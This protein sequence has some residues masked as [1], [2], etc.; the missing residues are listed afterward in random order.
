MHVYLCLD[1]N[2]WNFLD[3]FSDY[4]EIKSN[5]PCL[6]YL[7]TDSYRLRYAITC[8]FK[9]QL[10]ALPEEEIYLF[11]SPGLG[12]LTTQ[13]EQAPAR[14]CYFTCGTYGETQCSRHENSTQ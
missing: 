1:I 7:D 11:V 12:F 2:F 4:C 14:L 6:L 3:C 9:G 5:L 13:V 8:R 10:S